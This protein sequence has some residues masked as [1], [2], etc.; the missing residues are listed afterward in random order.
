MTLTRQVFVLE[1]DADYRASLI[2][3]VRSAGIAARGFASAEAFFADIADD[4]MGVVLLDLRLPGMDGLEALHRIC[5]MKA[6]QLAVIVVTGWGDVAT[7]VKVMREGALDFL[8]KPVDAGR[9]LADIQSAFEVLGLR[10]EA[11][12][13]AAGNRAR[14]ESLSRRERQVLDLL[15]Q[16]G[17][18]KDIGLALHLS[19]RTI[20]IFRNNLM[21]KLGAGSIVDLIKLSL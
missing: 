17:R 11:N 7:A 12:A 16:G 10:R 13:K 9:L 3:L 21:K 14:L 18:T 19:P 4:P 1:D 20:E 8:E 5:A 2:S 15:I 6:A